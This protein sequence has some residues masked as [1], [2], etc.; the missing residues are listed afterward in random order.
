MLTGRSAP[1]WGDTLWT[2]RHGTDTQ[3][4]V[5]R[6]TMLTLWTDRWYTKRLDR[7]QCYAHYYVSLMLSRVRNLRLDS[8][9][10]KTSPRR[11]EH[12]GSNPGPAIDSIGYEPCNGVTDSLDQGCVRCQIRNESRIWYLEV[13]GC[14]GIWCNPHIGQVEVET[15]GCI[16]FSG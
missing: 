12:P 15:W 14:D 16:V 6:K 9:V 3:S 4:Q 1:N 8:L 7:A 13:K 11:W 2:E 10:V 5:S